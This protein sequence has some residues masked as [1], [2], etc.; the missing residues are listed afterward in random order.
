MASTYVEFLLIFCDVNSRLFFI[1]S[2]L[3]STIFPKTTK[4]TDL[5]SLEDLRIPTV[6][7]LK[8]NSVPTVKRLKENSVQLVKHWVGTSS[9]LFHST[10][11]RHR[12]SSLELT[13]LTWRQ[14]TLKIS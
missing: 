5:S 2:L 9:S 3:S 6:E 14:L 8:E 4:N 1:E 12:V 10:R 7:R 11:A 13:A